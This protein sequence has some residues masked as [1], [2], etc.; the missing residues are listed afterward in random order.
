[1]VDEALAL[2]EVQEFASQVETADS[3][4]RPTMAH[5][6]NP[7][8]KSLVEA[9]HKQLPL[10]HDIVREYDEELAGRIDHGINYG[11]GY[12]SGLAASNELVAGL[13]VLPRVP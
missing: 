12:G 13:G 6:D 2:H 11:S 1:M 7:A 4:W 5:L 10:I 8:H 9:I 3:Q